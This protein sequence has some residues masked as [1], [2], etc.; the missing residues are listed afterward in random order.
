[1]NSPN[2]FVEV[3]LLWSST[4]WNT[5]TMKKTLKQTSIKN[6]QKITRVS[7]LSSSLVLLLLITFVTLVDD[8]QFR[9]CLRPNCKTTDS[10]GFG[11]HNYGHGSDLF[12]SDFW[13]D[14]AVVFVGQTD[15]IN[16]FVIY[17]CYWTDRHDNSLM[18]NWCNWLEKMSKNEI[19]AHFIYRYRPIHHK[20]TSLTCNFLHNQTQYQWRLHPE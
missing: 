16:C 13:R 19:D 5:S 8:R 12:H 10:S 15:L 6:D 1:M 3:L 9:L 18:Q 14:E 7:S 11:Y 4:Q 20:N 2:S 17:S